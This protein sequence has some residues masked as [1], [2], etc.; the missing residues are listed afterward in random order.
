M[1]GVVVWTEIVWENGVILLLATT[2]YIIH[3]FKYFW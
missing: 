3:G 1:A 2:A